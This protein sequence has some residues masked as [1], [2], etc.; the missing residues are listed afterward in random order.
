MKSLA[1]EIEAD[2]TALRLA[3]HAWI[4]EDAPL[5][6]KMNLLPKHVDALMARLAAEIAANQSRAFEDGARWMRGVAA[7]R[8]VR[9]FR[10]DAPTDAERYTLNEAVRCVRLLPLQPEGERSDG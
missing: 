7:Q 2:T 4:R 6:A 1:A 10:G 3:V 9:S 5:A 8:V